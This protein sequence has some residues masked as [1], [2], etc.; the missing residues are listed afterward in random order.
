MIE[1]AQHIEAL[2]L[3]NDC[4]IVPDLGGFVAHYTPAMRVEKEN[5]FLPPTRIIGFNPQLRMNDGLLVQSYMA[6][7]GTSFS[8]ATKIV[9]KEVGRLSA[10]LHEEGKA[11]LP[12]VGELHYSIHNSYDFTPYDHKITTPGLYGLD[13]FEMKELPALAPYAEKRAIPPTVSTVAEGRKRRLEININRTYLTNAVAMIAVIALFFF[14][15]TPIENTE[16][17]EGNYAQMLPEELFEKIEKQSLAITPIVVRR[18]VEKVGKTGKVKTAQHRKQ[19][20]TAA[21]PQTKKKTVAPVAVKEVKVSQT[22]A[23]K[24]VETKAADTKAAGIK[25]TEAK[26]TAPYHIIVASM[27]TEKDAKSMAEQLVGKGFIGAKAIIGDGKMRVSIRS[28]ATET[29]A[30][31]A[32]DKIRQNETYK[33]AWVLKK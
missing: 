30:Y 5:L 2:L 10:M 12:N 14:L 19:P 27:G 18:N 16:V 8:D 20:T 33:N 3:E 15:S 31:Q 25:S 21:A 32:L 6:V 26:P 13:S 1:L 28:C 17:V 9:E 23:A 7:Y 22:T 24:A 11:D 4:V 29:E